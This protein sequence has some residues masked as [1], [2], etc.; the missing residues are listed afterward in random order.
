MDIA[1]WWRKWNHHKFVHLL[2]VSDFDE[3]ESLLLC[4]YLSYIRLFFDATIIM[5]NKDF[6]NYT[7]TE[8]SGRR[9]SGGTDKNRENKYACFT[10]KTNFVY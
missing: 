7:H 6:H 1:A 2:L 10:T 5:V 8:S 4:T 3:N 9:L